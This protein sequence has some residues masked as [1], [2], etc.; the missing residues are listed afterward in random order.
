MLRHT[1]LALSTLPAIALLVLHHLVDDGHM[2]TAVAH[3][4]S[5]WL[6]PLG[7]VPVV[8]AGFARHW[9]WLAGTAL[10]AVVSLFP[11]ARGHVPQ[12][13]GEGVPLRVVTAN[14]LMINTDFDAMIGELVAAEPDVMVLQ[15][16]SGAWADALAADERLEPWGWRHVVPMDGSFGYAVLSRIPAGFEAEDLLGVPVGIVTLDLGRPVE[17]LAV[18]TLPP[19]TGELAEVWHDQMGL[20]A[21]RPCD[22]LAGDLNATR[23]H[24]SYRRLLASGLRDAH[25][26]VGRASASTWPKRAF[27]LP[28]M[29]LD[30][31]LVGDGVGV[32]AVWELPPSG[33]DHAPVVADLRIR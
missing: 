2:L 4:A 15:E 7:I 11:V 3:A 1:V 33:S 29:R 28:P 22:I 16:V 5:G 20:L 9:R 10:L 18:H 30:H 32:A 14:V 8:L 13:T 23:H 21:D 26:E 31:V 25:A 6:F 12:P 17:L 27:P 19:R 24:P